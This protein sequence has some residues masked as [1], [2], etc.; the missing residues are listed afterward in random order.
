M[1]G[2]RHASE[3]VGTASHGRHHACQHP[4]GNGSTQAL[5][6]TPRGTASVVQLRFFAGLSVEEIAELLETST[7]TVKRDWA[8]AR[9]WLL[10]RMG[11]EEAGE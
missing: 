8:Y 5:G 3:V 4:R 7:A 1:A 9:A 10:E 6:W 11:G 2:S